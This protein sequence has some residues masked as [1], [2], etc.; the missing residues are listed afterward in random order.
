MHAALRQRNFLLFWTAS[1]VSVLGDWI[2]WAALPFAIYRLTGSALAT[3]AM[4]MVQTVPALL[5]GSVA[6]VFADRWE[7][8]RMVVV[9]ELACAA[10]LLPL[11]ALHSRDAVWIV[12]V[13]GFLLSCAWQFFL[14]ASG[15]LLPQ[16]VERER[17]VAANA[18]SALT[19]NAA[20]LIGP[21]LGG[22]VFVAFG[23]SGI[24]VADS[25]SFLVAAGLTGLV[26]VPA[27]SVTSESDASAP[28]SAAQ[29]GGP[30]W[31]D[32]VMGLRTVRAF[33]P[34]TTLFT[35]R[36]LAAAADSVYTVL[37]PVWVVTVLHADVRVLGWL[38]SLWG[39]GGLFGGFLLARLGRAVSPARLVAPALAAS[40][41][42]LLA[43]TNARSIPV[44]LLLAV[45][46]GIP[47]TIWA[48]SV[49]TLLQR[50]T[51][52][53]HRGRVFGSL[54]TTTGL[55][56]LVGFAVGSLLG[57]RFGAVALINVAGMLGC[58]AAASLLLLRRPDAPEPSIEWA[59]EYV[60]PSFLRLTEPVALDSGLLAFVTDPRPARRRIIGEL[61]DGAP[62]MIEVL[63]LM[64][65][66]GVSEQ[67]QVANYVQAFI[68]E[69]L[70][71]CSQ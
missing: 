39:V 41:L 66:D 20:R 23:L 4:F 70:A 5:L 9:A 67:R 53:E 31:R 62:Q 32:W 26:A 44:A 15:A 46:G 1:A 65:L 10:L 34:L 49:Q 57:D 50:V 69:A 28:T 13:V 45:L 12:Y 7:R 61:E 3:G 52:D 18:L 25:A 36:G 6:G 38:L 37:F 56:S 71:E 51:S 59:P 19:M 60:S 2:L 33:R 42:I 21:P 16:L 17:L 55:L 27:V 63:E 29:R 11:L 58:L 14:P 68:R 64:A 54:G 47:S 35:A 24:A 8:R 30:L 40:W 43:S 22:V 48:V